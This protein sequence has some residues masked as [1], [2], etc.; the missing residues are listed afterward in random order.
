MGYM[1]K[2]WWRAAKD[3]SQ[4]FSLPDWITVGAIRKQWE[5]TESRTESDY[6]IRVLNHVKFMILQE[7][8]EHVQVVGYLKWEI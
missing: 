6:R 5:E 2:N 3:G 1:G 8:S 4:A 7:M